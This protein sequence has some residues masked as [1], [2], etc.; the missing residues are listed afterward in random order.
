MTS[1]TA[2]NNRLEVDV[3]FEWMGLFEL[4]DEH[5]GIL[6]VNRDVL[7]GDT[8]ALDAGEFNDLQAGTL[9]GKHRTGDNNTGHLPDFHVIQRIHHFGRDVRVGTADNETVV[10]A[11]V[12]GGSVI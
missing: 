12:F 11:V 10:S 7:G 9:P 6:Q 1:A 3:G 2:Q 5:R 8:A 4:L